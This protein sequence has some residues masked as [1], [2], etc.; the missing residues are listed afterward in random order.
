MLDASAF[1]TNPSL[2]VPKVDQ[3]ALPLNVVRHVAIDSAGFSPTSVHPPRFAWI[4][5][6]EEKKSK[7][8]VGGRG[9]GR[10]MYVLF[11]KGRDLLREVIDADAVRRVQAGELTAFAELYDRYARLV[12]CLSFDGTG[13]L[14]DANDICQ[15]VF[16]KAYR[17]LSELREPGRFGFWLTG[18]TRN[19]IVD[20]KRRQA[21]EK[22]RF[23]DS[24]PE[25]ASSVDEQ[26]A[27]ETMAAELRAQIR[28]LPETERMA[29]H[30]FY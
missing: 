6:A 28:E 7:I 8:P 3:G 19:T 20:W 24:V 1:K 30:L 16:M 27:A 10:S 25:S 4:E 14:N 2:K 18:I 29:L 21:R 23:V 9:K 15:E 5:L 26:H 12:R 13:N 17:Q 11:S 22:V